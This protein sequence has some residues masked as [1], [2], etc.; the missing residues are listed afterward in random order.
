[1]EINPIVVTE[2]ERVFL[3]EKRIVLLSG[4]IEACSA[5]TFIS[6][7]TLMIEENKEPITIIISSNGGSAEYG[8]GCIRAIRAAQKNGIKV[9]GAVYG[10]AMSMAFFIL[11]IC[12]ERVMGDL[13]TIMA[14][15]LTSTS[16]GDMRNRE[17]EN[18]L[19]KFFQNEYSVLLANRSK[20]N[21]AWWRKLLSD[22]TPKFFTSKES[23]KLGLV[24]RI[25]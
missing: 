9:I 20:H 23:L 14:H 13:D 2:A 6:D 7:I 11:Q 15:G 25:E 8:N 19:L 10:Q 4:E 16:V 24:D 5:H 12:D 21:V 1:M 3:R 18:K 22:N 17:A